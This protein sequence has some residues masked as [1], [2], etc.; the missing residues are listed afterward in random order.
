MKTTSPFSFVASVTLSWC[1]LQTCSSFFAYKVTGSTSS[2]HGYD[3]FDV[4]RCVV[5]D[6]QLLTYLSICIARCFGYLALAYSL[7]ILV[8]LGIRSLFGWRGVWVEVLLQGEL[9]WLD[10]G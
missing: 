1:S 8:S 6:F 7:Y 10:R 9:D 5:C 4:R 2:S 3:F